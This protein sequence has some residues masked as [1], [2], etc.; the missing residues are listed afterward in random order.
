MLHLTKNHDRKIG[1][2]QI[3]QVIMISWAEIL[4]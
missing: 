3:T 4:L 2:C 1:K